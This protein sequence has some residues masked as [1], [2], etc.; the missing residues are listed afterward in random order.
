ML[1]DEKESTPSTRVRGEPVEYERPPAQEEEELGGR[2]YP[3]RR[4]AAPERLKVQFFVRGEDSPGNPLTPGLDLNIN[5]DKHNKGLILA[6]LF[7]KFLLKQGLKKYY[8]KGERSVMKELSSLHDLKAWIP[9]D[10]TK[11]THEQRLHDLTTVVFLKEKRDGYLKTRACVN[12]SSQRKIWSKDDVAS[13]TP[14]LK[15]VLLLPGI[16]AWECCKVRC[17]DIPSA[18]PTTDMDEEVVMILKGDLSDLLIQL[19]PDL[20]GPYTTKDARGKTLMYVLLQK[21][22]YGLMRSSLLFYRKFRGELEKYGFVVNPYD[23]CVANYTTQKGNQFTV[24]W[25][26]DDV[27]ASYAEDFEITK[28]AVYLSNIYGPRLTMHTGNKFDYLGM[29][30][31]FEGDGG[32]AVSMFKHVDAALDNFPEEVKGKVATPAANHLFD[33]REEGVKP[34]HTVKAEKFHHLTVHL[35]VISSRARCDLQTTVSFLTT[36]VK[37]PEADDWGKLCCAMKYINGTQRLKL[38]LKINAMDDI[39]HLLWF[40]DASHYVH[41][42]RKGHGGTALMMVNGA[43]SSYLNRIK[44]N[45]HSS[46]ETEAVAIDR[47]MSEVLWTMYFLREQGYPIRLLKI[48]QDNETAQLLA[49]RGRLSSTR[50]TKHF[51]NKLF[52]VKDQV[53]QGEIAIIDCPM[54]KMWADFLSKP[55]QGSL[56]Q[57][58]WLHAMGCEVEYVDPLDPAPKLYEKISK[59]FTPLALP[60]KNRASTTYPSAQEC[61][62]LR[63][64]RIPL[65]S[66]NLSWRD[67]VAGRSDPSRNNYVK[68]T[69]KGIQGVQERESIG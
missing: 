32:V 62:G 44:V 8:K 13:P 66:L 57:L 53:D 61:V 34:L 18:F 10:H 49:M 5:L 47:Y 28:F 59:V 38:R 24:V 56:F 68:N 45:T 35:L 3:T 43:M 21:V 23:P 33:V 20:Y 26:V 25:H 4:C 16:V 36:R 48:A 22:L 39:L 58:M 2:R 30:L 17:F 46:S 15:S 9:L 51:K 65:V 11:L 50:R 40:I 54:G 42:D 64:K 27:F 7:M 14:H 12:G 1:G 52:F 55:Q 41:W 63:G 6:H 60:L 29:D 19:A 37:G 69:P 67:D 31:K